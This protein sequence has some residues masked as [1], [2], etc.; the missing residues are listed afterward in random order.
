MA[1]IKIIEKTIRDGKLVVTVIIN[2]RKYEFATDNPTVTWLNE[3]IKIQVS[4]LDNIENIGQG[5]MLGDFTP[6]PTTSPP[7]PTPEQ[8]KKD[9]YRDQL[10]LLRKKKDQ[11]D[12]GL[13]GQTEYDLVKGE[14]ITLGKDAGEL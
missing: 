13:I 9:K 2:N 4:R 1:D 6:I 3:Q 7:K 10:D 5:I 8:I 11:L 12:L 14:A